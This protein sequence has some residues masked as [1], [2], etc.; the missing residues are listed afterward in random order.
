MRSRDGASTVACV[1]TTVPG[2]V[3]RLCVVE[4]VIVVRPATFG[5]FPV[6]VP[7]L[8][9]GAPPLS[10][11]KFGGTTGGGGGTI[12]TGVDAGASVITAGAAVPVGVATGGAGA[13]AGVGKFDGATAGVVTV[14][15]APAGFNGVN[16]E[17]VAVGPTVVGRAAFG[18]VRGG[19]YNV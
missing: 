3:G 4:G 16:G 2:G 13:A 5:S 12:G 9:D 15:G 19:V 14:T 1:C 18:D 6:Q 8:V 7:P 17:P 10:D 11:V